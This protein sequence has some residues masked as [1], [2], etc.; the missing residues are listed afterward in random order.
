MMTTTKLNLTQTDFD[1]IRRLVDE[2]LERES[3]SRASLAK[4]SGINPARLS[5]FMANKYPGDNEPIA[6]SLQRWLNQHN[7]RQSSAGALPTAPNFITTRTAAKILD[8]LT[9][10]QLASDITVIY[11]GAG[12]GKTQ[13]INHYAET[14]NNVWVCTLSPSSSTVPAVLEEIAFAIGMKEPPSRSARARRE[15]VERVRNTGGLLIID[16]AQHANTQ[17]LDEIRSLHDAAGI[18]I[19]LVGNEQVYSRMAGGNRAAYLDRLFSRVGKRVKLNRALQADIEAIAHAWRI[20]DKNCIQELIN[21]GSK[22]GGIR[23]VTKV[24]RLAHMLATGEGESKVQH[25]HIRDAWNDLGGT[26]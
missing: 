18:G 16:E 12:L 8:A 4:E 20:S 25:K 19:A 11:G 6:R 22:P 14:E 9:W 17:A 23:G 24:M 26:L 7:E 10:A 5:Q 1:A 13:S 15:I 3:I 21:I 2:V